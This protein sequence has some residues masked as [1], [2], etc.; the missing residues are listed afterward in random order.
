M[1]KLPQKGP[2]LPTSVFYWVLSSEQQST[3]ALPTACL[4][5]QAPPTL[6]SHLGA[7]APHQVTP[8]WG[9]SHFIRGHK[10]FTPILGHKPPARKALHLLHLFLHRASPQHPYVTHKHDGEEMTYFRL[11]RSF[12]VVTAFRNAAA[13][14]EN[15]AR[16]A[17]ST[18]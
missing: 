4:G 1:A 9:T 8:S 3:P 11:E 13:H 17:I 14:V 5:T 2:G 15:R 16:N 10:P 6:F 7:Q 18:S 12:A